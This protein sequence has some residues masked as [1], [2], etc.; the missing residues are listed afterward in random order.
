MDARRP[1]DP[2]TQQRKTYAPAFKALRNVAKT[3]NDLDW[4]KIIKVTPDFLVAPV[5]DHGETSPGKDI[6]A[7]IAPERFRALLDEGLV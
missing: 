7:V 4:S 6:K 3:L 2:P 1:N 5:D